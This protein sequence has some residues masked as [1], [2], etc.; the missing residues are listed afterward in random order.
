[1]HVHYRYHFFHFQ[2]VGLH[3]GQN[4]ASVP[5]APTKNNKIE[6]SSEKEAQEKVEKKTFCGYFFSI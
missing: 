2:S 4:S 1:M 3:E 6:N 5:G